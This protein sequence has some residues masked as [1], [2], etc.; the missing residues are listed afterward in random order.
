MFVA[1]DARDERIQIE[2]HE[3]AVRLRTAGTP[4][5]CPA[6]REELIIR[7]G[8]VLPAHFAHRSG[9]DCV[10]GEPESRDHLLGKH[11]LAEWARAVG[12]QV[13]FEVYFS[14]IKQ[15][16]DLVLRRRMWAW[17]GITGTGMQVEELAPYPRPAVW[18][19]RGVSLAQE[20]SRVVQALAYRDKA[21]VAV[22]S[23]CYERGVNLGGCPV[24]VHRCL[25]A[26]AG[27]TDKEW[28]V[29]VRW[30]LRFWAERVWSVTASKQWWC[31]Y[32]EPARVPL[33]G[34][35]RVAEVAATAWLDV[36]IEEGYLVRE[37]NTLRWIRWPRWYADVDRK[38]GAINR[39]EY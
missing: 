19:P 30:L 8:R 9:S 10:V 29:R 22:Q 23:M 33:L 4:Y 21:A 26:V 15:R 31:D 2:T 36:L 37:G 3:Q 28:L 20:A 27:L 35:R 24:V 7:N 16:A 38:L 6:C 17:W 13:D 1:L 39:G 34:Q 14:G 25:T 5:R 18:R 11:L 32:V 12:W